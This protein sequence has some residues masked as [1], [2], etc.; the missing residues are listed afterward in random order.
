MKARYQYRIYPTHR[1]QQRLAQVF[2]C[3][4]VVWNDALA[5]VLNTPKG[6]QWPSNADLQKL[7]ITQAKQSAEREWLSEV[8]NIPLQQSVA[9]LGVAFKN[10]F[11]SLSGKRKGP[12]VKMPNFKRRSNQQS[13][14]YRK[15]GFGL[16]GNK[17][18]LAKMGV[19]KV[20]WSRPLPAEPSSVTVIKDTSNRYFASFVVESEPVFLPAA[21]PSVGLDLGLKTFAF[22]STGE[23]VS[24]PGYST[25]ERKIRRFQR[26]MARQ[27]KGSN[28]RARTRLKIAKL[29][30]KVKAIRKDFLHKLSTRLVSENQAVCLEDL[31]VKGMVKNRRLARA[32]SQQGWGQ[33]RAL[34]ESKALKYMGREVRVISRWE[35]TSQTCSDCGFR[36]GKLDLSV[37]SI[38]CVSCG[39]A[40]DRD[41]NAAKNVEIVGVGQTHDAK[42]TVRARQSGLPAMLSDLSSPSIENQLCLSL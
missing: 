27:V 37:R 4:R 29:Q 1:Q 41:A 13:A 28:R 30:A 10:F 9:D 15:G 14:R 26:Q 16:K 39:I 36:W 6:K 12:K 33:F 18:S 31:N 8:S 21:S 5:I 32:I 17:L 7:V 42:R 2:G 35:P 19:F 11:E 23:P 38:R 22:L 34:C 25:L 20:R 40:H 3:T 24:A